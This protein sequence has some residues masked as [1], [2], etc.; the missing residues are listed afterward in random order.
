MTTQLSSKKTLMVLPV[1]AAL[2]VISFGVTEVFAGEDKSFRPGDTVT[3]KG[4]TQGWAVFNGAA[5]PATITLDGTATLSQNNKWELETDAFVDFY[6]GTGEATLRGNA[7][8]GQISLTGKGI[9]NDGQ[10]FNLILRGD[11]APIHDHNDEFALD[12]SFAAIH[13]AKNGVTIP[14]LQSGIIEL[15][16]S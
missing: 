2:A 14:L 13:V 6:G 8:D 15:M 4:E 11:Y 3:I 10:S 16:H 9:S 7:N 5:H 1:L 12:F